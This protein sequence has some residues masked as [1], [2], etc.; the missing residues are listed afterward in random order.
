[1]RVLVTGGSGFI[2][3]NVCEHLLAAGI[4]CASLD[5]VA[6]RNPAH[7][8]IWQRVDLCDAAGLA[9]AVRRFAPDALLHLGARTDLDGATVADYA[10]NTRGVENLIDAASAVPGLR[11]VVF[12]SSRLVCRIGYTPTSDTDWCPS[13]AYGQSKVE[14]EQIVRSRAAQAPWSWI[15]VRPTSIWGP[16]FGV[17]YR[18]FFDAVARGRYIHPKGVDVVKS[19]GFV[20]NTVEQLMAIVAAPAA[21][22]DRRTLYLADYPPIHVQRM[23]QT[24]REQLGL[25]PGR[26]VPLPVLKALAGLGDAAKA[27]GWREPPLTRFRLANL[28]TPMVYDLE[29]LAAIAGPCRH[30]MAEGVRRTLAWMRAQGGL[31]A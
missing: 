23:A 28:V 5:I 17:P 16:W 4:P 2:G 9:D 26:E 11:R 20:G 24:I 18:L 1:M 30:D 19:F 14:G 27:L 25:G 29:P 15:Q 22:I 7:A 12:A 6:P 8:A 13:T 10:A 31:P 21:Q 3:T